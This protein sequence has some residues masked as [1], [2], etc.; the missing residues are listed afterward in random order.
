MGDHDGLESVITIGWNTHK[1]RLRYK[2]AEI[3]SC[4][5]SCMEIQGWPGMLRPGMA[6]DHELAL[7]SITMGF[8]RPCRACLSL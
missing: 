7:G 2:I 5:C 8:F 1:A 6:A 4:K 3:S